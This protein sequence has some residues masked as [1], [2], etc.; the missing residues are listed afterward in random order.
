MLESVHEER[1]REGKPGAKPR[2]RLSPEATG[3]QPDGPRLLTR[4]NLYAG[5]RPGA[6]IVSRTVSERDA[7]FLDI[8]LV[9]TDVTRL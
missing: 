4:Y 7:K 2:W 1:K 5:R 6:A 8:A 9:T 3:H